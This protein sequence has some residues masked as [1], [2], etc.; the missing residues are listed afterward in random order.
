MVFAARR[1]AIYDQS[2]LDRVFQDDVYRR[3]DDTSQ[4]V[5]G[6]LAAYLIEGCLCHIGL[7]V[8]VEKGVVAGPWILSKWDD[9]SGEDEHALHDVP[10]ETCRDPEA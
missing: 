8:R 2:A 10:Y 5:P 9:G 4:V 7:V 6:D 3:L 1:T